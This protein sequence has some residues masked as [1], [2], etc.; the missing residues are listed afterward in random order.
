MK[1]LYSLYKNDP[2]TVIAFIKNDPTNLLVCCKKYGNSLLHIF[3]EGADIEGFR[4]IICILKEIKD[5]NK[6]LFRKI[7]NKQNL[8]GDTPAHIGV[9]KS[10]GKNNIYSIMVELLES[11]GA[12][13]TISNKNNDIIKKLEEPK[14]DTKHIEIKEYISNCL[15]NN[16]D[17]HHIESDTE[18]DTD[19]DYK[20][21]KKLD[22]IHTSP[23]VLEVFINKSVK[24]NTKHE[25]HKK[26]EQYGGR[27][28][29][30]ESSSDSDSEYSGERKLLNPY[31]NGGS[32]QSQKI[33]DEIIQKIISMKYT[34][35]EARDIKNVI[36]YEVK[37]KYPKLNND[38]RAE[39][40]L[41]IVDKKLANINIKDIRKELENYRERN[42]NQKESTDKTKKEPK[43]KETKKKTSKRSKKT[44]KRSRK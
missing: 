27:Q 33:H 32:K 3:M 14:Y 18:S 43:T 9:R 13:F 28:K 21:P 1:D 12:D 39:K 25:Q 5:T 7:V 26:H 35:E 34:E 20:A 38:Q 22:D 31:M 4:A 41:D 23:Y 19:N 6:C 11:I 16:N 24:D 44:S 40:M 2:K 10:T 42:N 29:N 36:Y 30:S 37:E 8:A 15:F 17:Y